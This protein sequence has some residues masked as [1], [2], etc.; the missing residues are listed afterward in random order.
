LDRES[1]T[2]R[3]SIQ[4]QFSDNNLLASQSDAVRYDAAAAADFIRHELVKAGISFTFETVF[5]HPSK[6]DFLHEAQDQ[7]YQVY[8]YFI[9]TVSPEINISRIKQRV[10]MGEHDVADE[11]VRDRYELSLSLLPALARIARRAYLFDNSANDVGIKMCAEIDEQQRIFIP[12]EDLPWWIVDRFLQHLF[13]SHTI[14]VS[15]EWP[16]N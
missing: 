12:D 6:L 11:K 10:H 7:G 14:D 16:L 5:S 8:L 13:S 3:Q 1:T 9:S 2:R 15:P 4:L